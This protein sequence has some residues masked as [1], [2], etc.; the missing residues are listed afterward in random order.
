MPKMQ[1]PP[2]LMIGIGKIKPKD[3]EDDDGGHDPES[4]DMAQSL[5]EAVHAKDAQGVCDAFDALMAL[6]ESKPH[7]EAG[8]EEGEEEMPMGG[9][10]Y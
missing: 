3:G 9:R 4:L 10:G 5:I 8:E 7:E 1:G 6:Y 2:G